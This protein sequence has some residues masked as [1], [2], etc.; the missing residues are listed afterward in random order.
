[1]TASGVAISIGP[2]TIRWYGVLIVLAMVFAVW[3]VCREAKRQGFDSEVM[4]DFCLIMIPTAIV[5]IRLYYVLTHPSEFTDFWGIFKIW[6]GGL[7]LHGG[8]I[9]CILVAVW[10]LRRRNISFWRYADIMMS[11]VI[12]GQAI[13]RWG[14][15]FNQEAYGTVTNLPWAVYV[16]GAYRHPTVLYESAWSVLV[17]AV[18]IWLMKRPH[19]A[20]NIF[21][22]YLILYSVGRFFIEFVR[23]DRVMIGS[24]PIPGSGIVSLACI[25]TGVALL[26]YQKKTPLLDVYAI[27]EAPPSKAKKK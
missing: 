10:Y 4:F 16:A 13:G 12:L 2:L 11:G 20:G 17:F 23:E 22:W 21:S 6:E 5:G 26:Y 15:Y 7:A 8:I 1:M 3:W 25:V 24:L 18:L 14:N 19:R 9:S 27:A